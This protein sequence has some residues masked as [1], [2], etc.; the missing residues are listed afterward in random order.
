MSLR[1]VLDYLSAADI[2]VQPTGLI[3]WYNFG[4]ID[5]TILESISVN[6][7]VIDLR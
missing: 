3:S 7:P 2:Y 4:D 5:N 1:K 6:T